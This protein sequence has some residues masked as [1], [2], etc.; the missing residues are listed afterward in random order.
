MTEKLYDRDPYQRSFEAAVLSCKAMEDQYEVI[1]DRTLFFPEEGGQSPDRGILGGAHVLDVQIKGDVIIHTLDVALEVGKTVAGEIDWDHRFSNM[2][3]HSGEHIFSGLVYKNYGYTNVG[4]HL[5]DQIVTMDFNGPLTMEQIA[6]LEWEVNRV[7][8]SNVEIKA[9]Y[10]TKE[11]LAQMEYRSKKE[12]DGA[13]RIVEIAGYDLCA[14]CAPHVAR[15]GEIGGFKIQ[16]LQNYKGGVRI[17]F[18]CGFRALAEAGKKAQILSELTGIL[19]TNQEQLAENVQKLKAKNQELQ[20]Q[21]NLAKQGLM[22]LKLKQ[23]P[24]DQ[25][26]VLLFE[27]DLDAAVMRNAVNHLMEVHEG[28]CGIF[29]AEGTGYKFIIGSKNI[30]CR[31]IATLLREK[32]GARGGGSQAMIQGSL[33]GEKEQIFAILANGF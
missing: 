32:L 1:L 33:Q 5:S 29:V 10:P 6:E 22:E 9:T 14:C 27:E 21:L 31:Q 26:D 7:I 19:T 20:F 28:I 23:I 15:T 16:S 24:K 2:Q 17:S 25:K 13:I 8:A 30:D 18:L 12:I 3:Q 4:F 11:E